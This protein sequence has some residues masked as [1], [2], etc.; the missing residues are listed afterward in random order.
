MS[1]T[2]TARKPAPAALA[3]LRVAVLMGGGSG[4][5]EVSLVTGAS[6]ASALESC[7]G[8]GQLAAVSAIEIRADGAWI[9][10][11]RALDAASALVQL[12]DVDVF[13]LGLH[14]GAGENGT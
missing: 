10:A 5:R 4:E 3:S 12:S 13:F 11:G 6:V 1:T 8:A 14:G 9:V 7:V 2:D